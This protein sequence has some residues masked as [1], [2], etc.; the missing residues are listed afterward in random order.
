MVDQGPKNTPR[1][2]PSKRT[3]ALPRDA[4]A[5]IGEKLKALY[6]DVVNQP[7]PE[8]FKDLLAQLDAS[9]AAMSTAS[10]PEGVAE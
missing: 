6:D 2:T 5:K 8:R 10:P 4:Q 9:A 1:T 7:V 3:P